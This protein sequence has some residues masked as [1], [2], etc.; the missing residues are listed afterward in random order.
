MY[1]KFDFY[2]GIFSGLV[3][4]VFTIL[5]IF[6]NNIENYFLYRGY[7]LNIVLIIVIITY[8]RYIQRLKMNKKDKLWKYY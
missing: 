7:L 8:V 2:F 1:T 5:N 3:I 6:L 4:L